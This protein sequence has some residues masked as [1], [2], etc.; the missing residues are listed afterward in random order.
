MERRFRESNRSVVGSTAVQ[1]LFDVRAWISPFLEEIHSHTHPHIFRF[2]RNTEGRA[3]MHYKN[4]T[5]E[6]WAPAQ[7]GLLLLKVIILFSCFDGG[8]TLLTYF[9]ILCVGSTCWAPS[10]CSSISWKDR[11]WSLESRHPEVR[12]S[13]DYE[14]R[15][16]TVVAKFSQWLSARVCFCSRGKSS[17]AVGLTTKGLQ[18]PIEVTVPP[19]IAQLHEKQTDG[20][21]K[22]LNVILDWLPFILPF[23]VLQTYYMPRV[24]SCV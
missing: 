19:K 10:A 16:S 11:P 9:C 1:Y 13:W 3:E 6:E 14:R 7:K 2:R 5:H 22:V 4:W 12:W 21:A 24:I 17:L 8:E 15:S 23:A 20:G 18:T